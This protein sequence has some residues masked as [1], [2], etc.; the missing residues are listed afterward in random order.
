MKSSSTLLNK[1]GYIV[2]KNSISLPE[3][4]KHKGVLTVKPEIQNSNFDNSTEKFPVYKENTK[5][6]YLPKVY[7]IENFGKPASIGWEESSFQKTNISFKGTLRSEQKEPGLKALESLKSER[8]GGILQLP[9]GFGKTCLAIW[10]MCQLKVKTLVVVHKEFLL[11]QWIESINKFAPGAKIGVIQGD[12]LE[13]EGSDI[14]IGMLQSISMKNYPADTFDSFNFTVIDECHFLGAK[15]FSKA[16]FK[17]VSRYTLG[18]SA[19]PTRPDGLEKVFKWHIGDVVYSVKREIKGITP[20]AIV[21]HYRHNPK[22]TNYKE[23]R[24]KNGNISVT[25]MLTLIVENKLRN[26]FIVE[27][28][29]E[30]VAEGRKIL[31]L[32]ERRGHLQELDKLFKKSLRLEENESETKVE[33]GLFVGGM[34]EEQRK[35]SSECNVIFGTFQIA[36]VGLDISGLDTLVLATSKPGIVKNKKGEKLS[37]SMEQSVGRIFRKEHTKIR[38]LIIDIADIFS[39]FSYQAKKRKDFYK[40]NG[41]EIEVNERSE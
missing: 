20:R 28:L 19:T 40:D 24:D 2:F 31:V 8:G 26:T 25:S 37:G 16:L 38:P 12:K 21:Y 22:K 13:I 35:I 3:A 18:L 14:C 39:V 15:V 27:K 5:K 7:G 11:K 33:S 10:L 1:R 29:L 32:S 6:L 4:N 41:Y 36:S 30:L 23:I 17:I 34:K 9:C